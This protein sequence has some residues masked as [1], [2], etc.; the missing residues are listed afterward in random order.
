M[1]LTLLGIA[2]LLLVSAKLIEWLAPDDTSRRN[3]SAYASSA[4]GRPHPPENGAEVL[5]DD[6]G[7]G[8]LRGPL[9]ARR[10]GPHMGSVEDKRVA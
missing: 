1:T 7:E 8:R 6:R 10:R 5:R 3:P 4:P 9:V 2:A